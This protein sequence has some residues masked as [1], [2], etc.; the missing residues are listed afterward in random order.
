MMKWTIQIFISSPEDVRP[1]RLIVERVIARLGREFTYHFKLVPVLWE[2]EPLLATEHFQIGITP[3]SKTDIAVVIL[4]S[5]LGTLLPSDE[6]AG[7]ISGGAVTGTEWEFEDAVAA[8]KNTGRPELLLYRKC[9]PVFASLED[10]EDFERQRE[11]KHR[12]EEFLR[13]WF[14][15]EETGTFKAASHTFER[16]DQFEVILEEHLRRL[17]QDRLGPETESNETSIRWHQGSPYRGLESFDVEH[18]PI[19]F[20][21]TRARNELR[22]LLVRQSARGCA[23]VMVLGA[24]GSGKSSLVKA[25]LIPDITLPGMVG[26][27]GMCRYG[28]CRPSDH[29]HGPLYALASAFFQPTGLPELENLE[30][31]VE[32]IVGLLAKA[33]EH[34]PIS[35][36]LR[37]ARNYENL[38]DRAETRFCLVV[39]QLEEIFTLE[40]VDPEERRL[41]FFALDALARSGIAWIVVTMRSDYFHQLDSIPPELS[42]SDT[43]SRYMLHPPNAGELGQ[44]IR[45]PAL[46]AGLRFEHHTERGLSLDEVIR[47]AVGENLYALPLIEFL[48]EQLWHM[49]TSSGELTF[50]AYEHLDGLEGALGKRA[51]E[52]FQRLTINEQRHFP[53]VLRLLVYVSRGEQ[54]IL[55]TRSVP[56][57]MFEQHSVERRIVQQFLQPEVRLL[58]AS[59]N[60]GTVNIRITHEALLTHWERAANQLAGDFHDLEVRS[61]LEEAAS[62]WVAAKDS[63]KPSLLLNPGFPLSEA[64]DLLDRREEE[65]G[66]PTNEYVRVSEVT[67]K[68]SARR[69]TRNTRRIAAGMFSLAIVSL[70]FALFGNIQRQEAIKQRN[71]ALEMESFALSSLARREAATGNYHDALILALSSVPSN[72]DHPTRPLVGEALGT[73]YH[74]LFNLPR[75]W[76]LPVKFVWL[77][78]TTTRINYAAFNRDSSQIITAGAEGAKIWSVSD[79]RLIRQFGRKENPAIFA[80]LSDDGY[81]AVLSYMGGM[82]RI[83]KVNTSKEVAELKGHKRDVTIANFSSD[84]RFIVTGSKDGTARGMECAKRRGTYVPSRNPWVADIKCSV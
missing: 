83:W 8:Y 70:M 33:P 71:E 74:T 32:D 73:L 47:T 64:L 6:F 80:K 23:F 36:G 4:W 1:E 82:V 48:L 34:L 17:L 76:R 11:Q 67:S 12:V 9:A 13:K 54:A 35:Q 5:R 41:F 27:V 62:V 68:R 44:L 59:G 56:L 63:D 29:K 3:P 40:H 28:V 69:K 20:G 2:R 45:Q 31:D 26:L 55:A 19:F 46:E 79:R 65:F 16:T 7:P 81:R 42:I 75:M 72:I 84:G 43:G 21:R 14:L 51:E 53:R 66:Q 24:S 39:D 77:P 38:T 15:D 49:R 10:E 37:M 30:F 61:R 22:E 52:E 50:A 25:G 60:V 18:A 78:Y 58:V 57:E